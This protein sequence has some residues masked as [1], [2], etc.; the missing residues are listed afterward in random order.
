MVTLRPA[1]EA[2]RLGK[3]IYERDIRAQVEVDHDGECVAIDVNSGRWA[4]ADDSLAA[5]SELRSRHPDAVDVWG[6]RVGHRA[7]FHF[8]GSSLRSAE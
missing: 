6:I 3:E 8:G 1:E 2:A 4:V 7:L 5:A